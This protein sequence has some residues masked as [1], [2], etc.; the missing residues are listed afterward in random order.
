M[1]PG[2]VAGTLAL[3]WPPD[4]GV[5]LIAPAAIP[6]AAPTEP[7]RG[8]LKVTGPGTLH[9]ELPNDALRARLEADGPLIVKL[10]SEEP[11][12]PWVE[13][14]V[15]SIPPVPTPDTKRE[16]LILVCLMV[17]AS[18]VALL[19]RRSAVFRGTETHL[20]APQAQ[21]S[22][23][24]PPR[25]LHS[26]PWAIRLHFK[27][28]VW[29]LL[30]EGALPLLATLLVPMFL[31][32]LGKSTMRELET[33]SGSVNYGAGF[34]FFSYCLAAAILGAGFVSPLIRGFQL[35]LSR[36]E[37]TGSGPEGPLSRPPTGESKPS[38][39]GGSSK[40]AE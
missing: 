37:Q 31:D 28:G 33:E 12:K 14:A 10:Q 32:L 29:P 24:P 5:P 23:R 4:A 3:T 34:V 39:E 19:F 36:W 22:W 18:G 9:L 25:G 17:A 2:T 6:L 38:A 7:L 40:K 35:L 13:L 11:L 30:K 27:E 16:G 26:L 20:A 1:Q 15:P 21:S 8:E